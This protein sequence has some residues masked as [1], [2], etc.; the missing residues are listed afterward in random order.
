ML[1]SVKDSARAL[2][3]PTSAIYGMLSQGDIEWVAIGTRKY[4]SRDV[5]TEFIK[6]NSHRGYYATR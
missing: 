3:I 6:Q 4:V 1:L 2:G 5:L